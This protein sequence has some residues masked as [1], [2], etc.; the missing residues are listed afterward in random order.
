MK[1]KREWQDNPELF[2]A[3]AEAVEG[4]DFREL[5]PARVMA[6]DEQNTY[7]DRGVIGIEV[8]GRRFLLELH[9]LT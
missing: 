6:W 2:E 3:I 9:E 4:A 8:G 7:G 5:A 1:T